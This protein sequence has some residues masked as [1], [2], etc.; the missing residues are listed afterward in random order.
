VFGYRRGRTVLAHAYAEPPLR[1]GR[2]LDHGS[3]AQLILV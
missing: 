3:I 1:V 2:L